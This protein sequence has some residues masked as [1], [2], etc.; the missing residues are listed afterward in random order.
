MP[1]KESTSGRAGPEWDA[2]GA[3]AGEFDLTFETSTLDQPWTAVLEGIGFRVQSDETEDFA[4]ICALPEDLTL[5]RQKY[6]TGYVRTVGQRSKTTWNLRLLWIPDSTPP[7]D[8]VQA[9]RAVGGFPQV[10]QRM[11]RAFLAWIST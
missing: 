2:R 4:R 11:G 3:E 10:L 6:L 9:S 7:E 5:P 8:F 1:A